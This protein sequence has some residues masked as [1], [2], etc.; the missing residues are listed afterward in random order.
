[1]TT[2]RSGPVGPFTSHQGTLDHPSGIDRRGKI[3]AYL[4]PLTLMLSWLNRRLITEWKINYF[5]A[6]EP[7]IVIS[8]VCLSIICIPEFTPCRLPQTPCPWTALRA[9]GIL[10][11]TSHCKGHFHP[12]ISPSKRFALFWRF[13]PNNFGSPV[14]EPWP[15]WLENS[16]VTIK[17]RHISNHMPGVQ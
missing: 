10:Q 1:M 3:K 4:C 17:W 15:T 9:L 7:A 2:L 14:G 11:A 13:M 16:R 6:F 12:K 5:H 8:Q